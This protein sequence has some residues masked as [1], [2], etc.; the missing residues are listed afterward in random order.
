MHVITTGQCANDSS[1]YLVCCTNMA[2][3]KDDILT[4]MACLPRQN[5][6]TLMMIFCFIFSGQ[7]SLSVM[8]VSTGLIFTIVFTIDPTFFIRLLKGRCHGNQFYG[9]NRLN[10]PT[11]PS[12]VGPAF[13]NGLQY[14]NSDF[15]SSMAMICQTPHRVKFRPVTEMRTH[16]RWSRVWLR[17]HGDKDTRVNNL[18]PC[19]VNTQQRNDRE[20]NPWVASGKCTAP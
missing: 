7:T 14:R 18:P 5:D 17:L 11:S 20:S 8:S 2:P 6:M 19:K 12:F 15:E 4:D 10:R 16:P 1:A 9:Q 3:L 13:Q